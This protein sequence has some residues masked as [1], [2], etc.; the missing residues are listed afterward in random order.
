MARKTPVRPL[1][2][3]QR[4][5]LWS[6]SGH[7]YWYRGC[8]WIWT[9]D[10]RTELL[11]EA[12]VKRGLAQKFVIH[13]RITYKPTKVGLD[14]AEQIRKEEAAHYADKRAKMEQEARE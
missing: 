13:G 10:R 9:T 7:G 5:F 8:F 6:F 11:C 1:G 3:V 2:S 4:D 12:M 14:M